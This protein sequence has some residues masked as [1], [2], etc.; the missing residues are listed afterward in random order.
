MYRVYRGFPLLPLPPPPPHP[1]FGLPDVVDASA[2]WARR[3]E[4]R[5]GAM[6]PPS[7]AP[8]TRAT[9]EAKAERWDPRPPGA[10]VGQRPAQCDRAFVPWIDC[11]SLSGKIFGKNR[12][13]RTAPVPSQP[14]SVISDRA[15][16][17]PNLPVPSN[18]RAQCNGRQSFLQCLFVDVRDRAPRSPPRSPS[19]PS[20]S[21]RRRHSRPST[22][23]SWRPQTR[24][25][26]S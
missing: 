14:R 23:S 7:P 24:S 5:P 8:L 18:R 26:R 15:S 13:P 4:P 9:P 16:V 17:A 3:P 22:R 11:R 1:P 21:H 12:P 6:P 2:F 25:T 19:V 20:P 10:P